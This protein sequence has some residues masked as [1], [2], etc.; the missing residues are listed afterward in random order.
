MPPRLS[1][2]EFIRSTGAAGLGV[3]TVGWS[4]VVPAQSNSKLRVLSIGVV[5]TIGAKDR[6]TV[7][8]HPSAEIVGLCDVDEEYLA[9]AAEDH[10]DAF[11]CK[12]YRTAFADRADE[13]DAVIVAT[14]DHSHATIMLTALAHDKHVYGQKPLVH[15]LEEIVL[16]ERAIAAKPD[17]VTQ[18]G[19][20]RM[21]YPGRRA[22]VEI[23]RS[24]VLGKAVAGYAWTGSPNRGSYF[25]FDRELSGPLS[26][27]E[28]LDWDLWLGP[29]A[30]RPYREHLVPTKWRSWW[31]FGSGGLGDWGVHVLDVIFFG[32]DELLSP[33]AVT[34]HAPAA[35]DTF[36]TR[37]CQST[38][39]Y[40][41]DSENF[42]RKFFPLHYSDS[43]QRPSRAA[44]GLPAGEWAGS[45]MTVVVCEGGVLALSA[46]GGLEIWRDG[47]MTDGL[48]MPGL[49]EF[50]ELNHWH[51]WVDTIL[52]VET[53]LRTPFVDGARITEAALLAVKASRFPGQELRWDKAAL[54]FT[55][56]DEA[57]A[58]IVKRNY[59]DG[60]APPAVG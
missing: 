27:P 8:E 42:A 57:T 59:R 56:N 22:A 13:F 3:A 35:A 19:N 29:C 30:E 7:A 12:D 20:Q 25:N 52:G 4:R 43:N 34:T 5:G 60:F 38:I 36:H 16:I 26:P 41:V 15:Q 47:T 31:D 23:L 32:Y 18:V 6:K 33:I 9:E 44:L 10:P 1:R 11:T 45:N 48:E 46:G 24:G 40:A 49:P 50:P 58:T 53:E 51:A 39:T 2:R 55:N 21:V 54:A 37:P 28:S 17:L 14:P